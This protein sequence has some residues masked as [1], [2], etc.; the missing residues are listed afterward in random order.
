MPVGMIDLQAENARHIL[1]Y[2]FPDNTATNKRLG[3]F[4]WLEDCTHRTGE[5]SAMAMK[6]HRRSNAH[7]CEASCRRHA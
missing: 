1:Q 4:S 5:N 6:R 2:R 3:F 7:C